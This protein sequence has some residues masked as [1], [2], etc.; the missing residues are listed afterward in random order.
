MK[1]ALKQTSTSL[2]FAV[3]AFAVTITSV[4]AF[5]NQ[6]FLTRAGLS[7]DQVIAIQVARELREQGDIAAARDALIAGGIDEKVIANLRHARQQQRHRTQLLQI[8]EHLTDDQAEALHVARMSNDRETFRA[9][10][11]EAGLEPRGR[12]ASSW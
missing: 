11:E 5:G 10:L 8:R 7:D 12:S 1:K 4:Q 3:G 2:A 9:I 6:E